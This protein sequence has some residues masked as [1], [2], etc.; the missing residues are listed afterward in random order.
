MVKLSIL[1]ATI[2]VLMLLVPYQLTVLA[3]S[4][5]HCKGLDTYFYAS[6]DEAF[7][8]LMTGEVDFIDWPLTYEQYL[9]ARVS[10]NLE[11]AGYAEDGMSEFDIN[12][13]YT[14]AD[15]PGVRSPTNDVEFRRALAQAVDK[16]YIVNTIIRGFAERIDCPIP[17]TQKGF[18][19]ETCCFPETYPY[20]YDLDAA[21]ARLDAAGYD[22]WDGDGWRNYP[23]DWPGVEGTVGVRDE[24]NIDCLKIYVRIDHAHRLA[25]GTLL[26]SI[27]TDD[28]HIQTCPVYDTSDIEYP[29]VMD[30]RNY[31]IYTGGWSLPRYPTYLYSMFHSDNWWPIGPNYVTGEDENGYPNYRDLDAVLEDLYF[32]TSLENFTKAVKKALGLIVCK[33][34]ITISLWSYKSWIAYSKYLVGIVNMEGYSL[35]NTYTFLNAYKVDNPDTV[36]DESQ[37]P[38]RMGTINAPKTL[39]ILYSRDDSDYAVL[40]RMSDHLLQANPYNRALDQP[41]IA[42]DWQ[43]TT[44]YDPQDGE[45]KTKVTYYIRK[46]VWWHAPLTGEAVQKFTAHDVEFSIWYIYSFTPF[47]WESVK[48]VHHTNVIDDYTIEVY[49][50]VQ[51]M[52]AYQYI[53]F[54][55]PFLCKYEL[56]DLLC[57]K[58]MCEYVVADPIAPSDKTVLSCDSIVQMINATKYPSGTSLREGVDYE[59]FGIGAPD[60]CHQEIHW[61]RPLE[62]GETV[63]FWYWASDLDPH[64]YYLAGLDWQLTFYSLGPYYV[65]DINPSVGGYAIMDCVDSHWLGAPPLGEIDWTWY[66]VAGPK[67][68]SGYYQVNL[69]DAVALLKAY[70]SRGDGI[71]SAHWFPGANI[72]PYDLSHVGLYDAVQLLTNYGKKFGTP[73]TGAP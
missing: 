23:L 67:P 33:Y 18:A 72:D 13:N 29:I 42:Q 43:E 39:N 20:P 60:Y 19:N 34:C 47:Q 41:W 69:Y 36:V 70:C 28:L 73:P 17:A 1:I 51:S 55:M 57:K 15:Y 4:P 64:G 12:N 38:I 61:L 50:D 63:V 48:N 11:L 68:R 14:I 59:V 7:E 2:A 49:F 54:Y 31:H 26:V 65:V 44:W 35:V 25:A 30:A 10:P 9:D 16:D 37:E 32:A 53:G 40:D 3:K 21:N 22:D 58:E 45:N 52:W 66:W 71:P 46:D 8:A 5:R 27:I 6:D 24:P 62:P 56:L